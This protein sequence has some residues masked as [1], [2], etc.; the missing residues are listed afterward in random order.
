LIGSFDQMNNN[1]VDSMSTTLPSLLILFD[2]VLMIELPMSS[3]A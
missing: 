3:I 2:H 1:F